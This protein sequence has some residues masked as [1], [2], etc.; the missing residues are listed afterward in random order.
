MNKKLNSTRWTAAVSGAQFNRG[1][2]RQDYET[3]L[4]FISAVKGRFG[5]LEADLAAT[6][7][8]TKAN[9]FI[10]PEQDSL[11]PK[12]EWSLLDG[13]LWL[14]PP[15]SNIAPWARKCHIQSSKGAKI[16]FLVPASVGSEWFRRSVF[17]S[18]LVLFLS[19]RL[20]FVG[21]K[22]PYPK[23]CIL[24]CYGWPAGFECWRWK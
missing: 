8:N 1:G 12:W 13:N 20:K 9:M 7:E 21:A 15:Y 19:P 5:P 22:D 24:C 18:A 16:L 11:L 10:T 2:S 3:P 4:D 14:N 6:K 23:D 17:N